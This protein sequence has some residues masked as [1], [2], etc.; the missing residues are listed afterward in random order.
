MLTPRKQPDGTIVFELVY[1]D[2]Q[3]AQQVA[4]LSRAEAIEVFNKL[5]SLITPGGKG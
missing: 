5:A 2:G 3:P 1:A 4:V